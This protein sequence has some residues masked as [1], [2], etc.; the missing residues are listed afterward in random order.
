MGALIVNADDFGRSRETTDRTRDCLVRGAVSA[1]SAMVFMEDSDRAAALALESGID[2]GLH[3]NLTTSFSDDAPSKL[4]QQQEALGKFLRSNRFASVLYHPGLAN[5]FEYVVAAQLDEYRRLFGQDPD[6][7]DGHHHMHLCSNVLV[8]GLLPGGTAIRRNFS[9]RAGEKG[10]VNRIFRKIVDG[11]IA[12]KHH[13][14]DF[15]FS[16]PPLQ[17][18]ARLERI[19]SL[20]A[21]HV[22]EV[23]CHPINP[24]EYAFLSSGEIFE[25][26]PKTTFR[27]FRSLERA[28]APQR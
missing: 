8:K 2:A 26:V 25:F 28:S 9:F 4:A 16:L 6:R 7:I 13:L 21:D 20:A 1:V 22:V 11:K 19:F 17:P 24:D 12:K 10:I 15:F 23:E 18:R 3:L 27:S 5:A 14:T